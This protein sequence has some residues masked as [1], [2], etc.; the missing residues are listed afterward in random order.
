MG[1]AFAAAGF[2]VVLGTDTTGAGFMAAALLFDCC[3]GKA[4][5]LRPANIPAIPPMPLYLFTGLAVA[6]G[7]AF[8]TKTL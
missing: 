7:H 3:C 1:A 4:P 8:G 5:S 2:V 6:A